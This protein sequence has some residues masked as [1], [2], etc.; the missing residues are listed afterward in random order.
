MGPASSAS[1]SKSPEA[2]Y[3]K[4]RC[5]SPTPAQTVS[6]EPD[7]GYLMA[8]LQTLMEQMP[9]LIQYVNGLKTQMQHHHNERSLLS[10]HFAL[11]MTLPVQSSTAV[12]SKHL[13][14]PQSRM[15][16]LVAHMV[17]WYFA[18]KGSFANAEALYDGLLQHS[19][20]WI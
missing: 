20:S 1:E 19:W 8:A 14:V 6:P 12:P 18:V 15:A 2:S 10:D 3:R 5:S 17:A 9:R 4:R 16:S 7:Q 13:I 11:E